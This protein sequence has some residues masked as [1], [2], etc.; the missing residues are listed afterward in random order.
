MPFS[1]AFVSKLSAAPSNFSSDDTMV[2]TSYLRIR[3]I[4]APQKTLFIERLER[5]P[6]PSKLI[7]C[8]PMRLEDKYK[9]TKCF[10]DL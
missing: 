3:A 4:R 9:I 8:S 10:L 1:G 2:I 5:L 6:P 7:Y